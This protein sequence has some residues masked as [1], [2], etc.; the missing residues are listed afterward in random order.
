M[1]S[2]MPFVRPRPVA[3]PALRLIVM[4]HAGGSGSTYFPLVKGLPPD[5]DLLLL[6]LPGRGK[7]HTEPALEDM[8]SVVALAVDDVLPW[9]GP[10]LAL[11]GHSFGGAVATEVAHVLRDKEARLDWLGVSGRVAPGLDFDPA[12]LDPDR[13]DRELM[14]A[15]A[16]MG[17]LPDRLD[18]LPEF[19][20]R[21]LALIRTD[22]HALA[23]YDP[24][25]GRP[26]LTVPLTVFSGDADPL[27]P[28]SALTG[29]ARETTG[30]CR[31]RTFPGGHFHFF[32][33]S[34]PDFTRAVVEE[35]R[36]A[37]AHPRAHTGP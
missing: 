33:P 15:L 5:W 12:L 19:R 21:F 27:A 14:A 25:P 34:F 20:D 23:T 26:P 28:P 36:T 6:D 13:P 1:I 35:I 7:R 9:A 3:D 11:F 32:G 29:W 17:G 8:A 4:P 18:E 24:M 16:A 37:L 2:L 31:R 10:P 22:L 30:P